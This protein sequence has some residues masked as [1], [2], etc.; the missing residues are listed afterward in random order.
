MKLYD[1]ETEIASLRKIESASANVAQMTVI[2][3]RRRIGKTALIK[4][5][6]T[7]IPFVYFFVVRKSEAL[8][9]HE[10]TDIVRTATGEDLGEFTSFARLFRALMNLS[11]RLN[12]T[13]VFDEFQNLHY[14]DESLFSEIQNIWDDTKDEGHVNLVLCG[15]VYSMMTKI[16]DNAR[17]PLYGRAT[18]RINLRPFRTATLKEILADHNST[19][20]PD[21]LLTLYM[22]TGGVLSIPEPIPRMP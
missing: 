13:L 5:S 20:H 10:L 18:H 1:G 17:E 21:D 2:T 12:Y 7:R 11:K 19:Y 4:Q 16:F 8:L 3:G 6:F 15:S 9:C 22:L 14:V